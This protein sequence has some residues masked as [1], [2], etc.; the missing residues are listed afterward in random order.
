LSFN[1]R[2]I[3]LRNFQVFPLSGKLLLFITVVGE[4]N[5]IK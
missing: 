5:H 1:Y 2:E 3:I 4:N